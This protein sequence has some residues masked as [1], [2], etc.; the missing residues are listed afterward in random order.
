MVKLR[1]SAFIQGS[2]NLEQLLRERHIDTIM[3]AG[4]A[5]NVCCESTARDGMMLNFHCVMLADANA[6][7]DDATQSASLANCLLF[8]GDVMNVSEMAQRLR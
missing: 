3:I 8:F 4:T 5:T 7:A 6:A 2:S 1:Y